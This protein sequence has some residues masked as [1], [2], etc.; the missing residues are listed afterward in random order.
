LKFV[1]CDFSPKD[2]GKI[3]QQKAEQSCRWLAYLLHFLG[4]CR[5]SQPEVSKVT[6][7]D[8]AISTCFSIKKTAL[9]EGS[10][11]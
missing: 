4:C 9:R 2:Q 3:Q 1:F 10:P 6:T 7:F 8:L 5:D 11:V